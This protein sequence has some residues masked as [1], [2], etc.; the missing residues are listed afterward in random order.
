MSHTD[1]QDKTLDDLHDD[2]FTSLMWLRAHVRSLRSGLDSARQMADRM[3]AETN[4]LRDYL[5]QGDMLDQNG[6]EAVGILHDHITEAYIDLC[7]VIEEGRGA[8]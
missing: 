2:A 4:I 7:Q 5:V 3:A 8:R 1:E 6:R